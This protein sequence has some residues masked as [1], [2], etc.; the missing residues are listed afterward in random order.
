[1]P[2]FRAPITIYQHWHCDACGCDGVVTAMS[3]DDAA[4]IMDKTKEQHWSC[5][6]RAGRLRFIGQ[7]QTIKP[8]PQIAAAVS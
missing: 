3:S 7:W 1:M 4:T 5:V 8:Q 6:G 2:E